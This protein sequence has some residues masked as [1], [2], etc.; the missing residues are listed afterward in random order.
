MGRL[1]LLCSVSAIVLAEA[2]VVEWTFDSAGELE[3]WAPN[4]HLADVSVVEGAVNAEAIEGD[5]YFLCRDVRFEARPWQYVRFRMKADHAGVCDLYWSGELEGQY[6]GL[7]ESKKSRFGVAGTGEW[8]EIVVFPFWQAEGTIRQLRLDLYV[9]ARFAID[10]IQIVEWAGGNGAKQSGL[11]QELDPV[12]G[13][14]WHRIRGSTALWSGPMELDAAEARWGTV[15]IQSDVNGTASLLWGARDVRGMQREAF[16]IQAG[17]SPRAYH[18]ELGRAPTWKSPIVAVAVDAPASCS[19]YRVEFGDVPAGPADVVVTYFGFENAPNRAGRSCRVLAQYE[20]RGGARAEG[21]Q[22]ELTLPP[23]LRLAGQDS[24]QTLSPL[25]HG[26]RGILVWDVVA[27]GPGTYAATIRSSGE[28]APPPSTANLEYSSVLEVRTSDYVPEP[29][30]VES[31]IEVAA[32][33]FPGWETKEKW[34]CIRDTARIRKPMLGYYDEGNPE[35]VDWQIKWAVEN[36]V[37]VFLVDWYWV[38]GRQQLTHWFNAYK[39]A[40]Y[41]DYLKVAI[42]WANHNPPNTHS[43]EDWRKVTRE[44]IDQYFHLSSYYRIDDKPAVFLW[45]PSNLRNDL[46]GSDAV[47]EALNESQAMARDAGY[48]GI[49]F[50]AMNSDFAPSSVETL[51]GE[52]FVGVTTYH[53]WGAVAPGSGP[54]NPRSFAEVVKSA[55]G[56]WREKNSQ[57]GRLAYYPVVDTGWDSRPWHGDKAF[58]I[59]GRTP[60]LFEQL[61]REAKSFCDEAGKTFVILGP[62][63]EWGEGSYIEPCTEFGFDMIERIRRVFAATPP[64]TWPIHIGPADLGLESYDYP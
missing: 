62:W 15:W 44:W 28:G 25:E 54:G 34:D 6:G 45:A 1:L 42:M 30:P 49:V 29:K 53:E 14:P 51:L 48:E 9:H 12:T 55:P 27:D 41:R 32:Y 43:R 40:R 39:K 20:N 13:A 11:P 36:C 23:G 31:V 2:P 5:P 10:S 38:G 35:C 63:N 26:E 33:Y 57:A 17:E 47:R 22:S 16:P 60:E 24:E 50:V 58:V 59:E 61:L 18:V 3:V 19:V 4:G 37:S 8:E 46:G 7:T 52:G 56:A 64:E 21:I